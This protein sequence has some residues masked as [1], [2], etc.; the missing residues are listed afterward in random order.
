M[1]ITRLVSSVSLAA[2]LAGCASGSSATPTGTENPDVAASAPLPGVTLPPG[3]LVDQVLRPDEVPAGMVPILL[4]S[5][6]RDAKV[7]ASYSGTGQKA[8]AAEAR[9]RAHGFQ[10]A[11]VAQYANKDTAQV[12]VVLVSRFT[13]AQ[14]AAADFADDLKGNTGKTVPNPTIGEQSA[15]TVQTLPGKPATDL[16]LVR[17]RRDT[18]TWSLAYRAP[19]PAAVQLPIQLA[20]HLLTRTAA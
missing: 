17:F 6:P 12:L 11:Y 20:G 8:A 3:Q 4:G 15:V 7:V 10:E 14:N 2:L 1:K 9:L 5:G 13:T 19:T 18:M 16:V